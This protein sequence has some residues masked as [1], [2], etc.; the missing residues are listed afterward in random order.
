MNLTDNQQRALAQIAKDATGDHDHGEPLEGLKLG[1]FRIAREQLI[2][3]GWVIKTK[4]G[5]YIPA[6]NA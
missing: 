4:H 2:A 6:A 5:R 1:E 3:K